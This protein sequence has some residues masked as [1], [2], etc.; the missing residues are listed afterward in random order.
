MEESLF[1]RMVRGDPASFRE[2]YDRHAGAVF[3][4][5][6]R[7]TGRREDA[8]DLTQDVFLR[9]WSSARE[10]RGEAG[11]ATWLYRIAVHRYLDVTRR[12]KMRKILSL[13]FRGAPEIGDSKSEPIA[14]ARE[15]PSRIYERNEIERILRRAMGDLPER[16]KTALVLQHDGGLSVEEIAEVLGLATGSVESLLHRAK[17]NLAALANPLLNFF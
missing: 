4:V 2:F 3:T 11:P 17:K 5:C 14:A 10:F 16:Q 6:Y 15:E 7:L 8:E 9:A 12:K 13:D 1:E